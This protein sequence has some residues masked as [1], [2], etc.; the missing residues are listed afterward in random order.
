VTDPFLQATDLALS[1]ADGQTTIRALDGVSLTLKRGELVVLTG[2]SGSGKTSLLATLGGLREPD[3]G[4]VEIDGQDLYAL[5]DARRAATRARLGIAFQEPV[6]LR[7]LDLADNVSYPLVPTGI[8]RRERRRRAHE[9]L[10]RLGLLPRSHLP[11]ERLS[12]GERRRVGLARALLSRPDAVLADE[13]TSALDDA[14][15]AEIAQLLEEE[16]ARGAAVLVVSHHAERFPKVDRHVHLEA[17]R[18]V[19]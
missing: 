16:R 7:G 6:F 12:G 13:P 5:P 1:F 2:P 4:R 11:P 9:L 8:A 10:D 14:G 18:R 19:S 15:A 17:G 3:A